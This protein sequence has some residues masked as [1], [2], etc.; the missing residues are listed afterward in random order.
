[1][2]QQMCENPFNLDYQ[3]FLVYSGINGFLDKISNDKIGDFKEFLYNLIRTDVYKDTF[4]IEFEPYCGV[5]IDLF[6]NILKE[7]IFLFFKLIK[8]Y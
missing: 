2:L 4:E 6:E 3:L 7:I 5:Q 8:V 1:M